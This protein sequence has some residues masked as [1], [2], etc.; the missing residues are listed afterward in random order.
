M[1]MCHVGLCVNR[2]AQEV[3]AESTFKGKIQVLFFGI[4]DRLFQ[5]LPRE[6]AR[7][8]LGLPVESRIF[9]YAGRLLELKGVQDLLDAFARLRRERPEQDLRL[10]VLGD[11]EYGEALARKAAELE[12]GG[13][14]EFR[15]AVPIEQMATYMSAADAF[16]LPSRAEWNEQFGRVNAEAMLVGTT[17]IG[18]TSGEIPV[19]I[20]DGGFVFTAGDVDDLARTMATVLDDPE[21]VARRRAR[22]REIAMKNYSLKGFVDGLVDLFEEITARRIRRQRPAGPG[23]EG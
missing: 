7:A 18:S 5:G 10:L 22:G 21:Q 20:Q 16:V 19:V 12:L 2:R 9:L 4:N 15:R 3:L 6:Q 1:A 13:S 23:V 17:I 11:G 8:S 14:V